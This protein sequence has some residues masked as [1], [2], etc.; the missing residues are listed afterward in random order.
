MDYFHIPGSCKYPDFEG[1][2]L[3]PTRWMSPLPAAVRKHTHSNTLTHAAGQTSAGG[4]MLSCFIL[5][6]EAEAGLCP[7][8]VTGRWNVPGREPISVAFDITLLRVTHARDSIDARAGGAC[9]L[10]IT[11]TA[12]GLTWGYCWM[13]RSKNSRSLEVQTLRYWKCRFSTR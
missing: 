5:D 4:S 11:E 7:N 8:M 12:A 13:K 2:H 9:V 6:A 1:F 10:N 3:F